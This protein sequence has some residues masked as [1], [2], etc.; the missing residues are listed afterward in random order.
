MFLLL[1]GKSLFIINKYIKIKFYFNISCQTKCKSDDI[2][3]INFAGL[4]YFFAYKKVSLKLSYSHIFKCNSDIEHKDL[5]NVSMY[6]Y[7]ETFMKF[8][9]T[10]KHFLI[11]DKTFYFSW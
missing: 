1:S 4:E 6:K 2:K 11:L 5:D 9:S 3:D 8:Q 10:K 7:F